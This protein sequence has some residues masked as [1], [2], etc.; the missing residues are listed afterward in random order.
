MI[1]NKNIAIIE[2]FEKVYLMKKTKYDSSKINKFK[3][4]L[5]N[6]QTYNKKTKYK[7]FIIFFLFLVGYYLYFL[8]L[9]K[10]YEGQDICCMKAKWIKKN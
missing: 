4:H 5:F 10:C 8:S 6:K 1:K 3:M 2:N 9:E 7:N